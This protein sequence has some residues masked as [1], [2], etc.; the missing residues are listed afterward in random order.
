MKGNIVVGQSGGPTA[1][2]NSSVAGVYAAA[3]KLG[4]KNVYGMVHGIEG[5]L[6]DKLIELED[7][8]DAPVGIE[9]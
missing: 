6:E 8:L 4:V 2:I 1:V 3:K 9:L 7:Y 5:F